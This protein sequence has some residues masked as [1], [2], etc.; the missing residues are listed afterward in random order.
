[1]VGSLSGTAG[2]ASFTGLLGALALVAF[3]PFA[4]PDLAALSGGAAPAVAATQH[5]TFMA[6]GFGLVA[7]S[8][9]DSVGRLAGRRRSIGH[10]AVGLL[11]AQAA[12]TAASATVPADVVVTIVTTNAFGLAAAI[13]LAAVNAGRVGV[14]YAVSAAGLAAA[15]VVAVEAQ[16]G[17]I[18][19][20]IALAIGFGFA[21]GA[22]AADERR[23]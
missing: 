3:A 17:P 5:W 1:V 18:G 21:V 23:A 16:V 20:I 22:L 13:L 19:R 4:I 11:A 15:A 6:F 7:L 10:L 2:A 9:R 8:V 14:A 12:V